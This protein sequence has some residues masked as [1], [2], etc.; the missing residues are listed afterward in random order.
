[1]SRSA[2]DHGLILWMEREGDIYSPAMRLSQSSEEAIER[3]L[4]EC[5]HAGAC[6]SIYR[7]GTH[8]NGGSYCR[9]ITEEVAARL[10]RLSLSMRRPPAGPVR[11]FLEAHGVEFF[12]SIPERLDRDL[13]ASPPFQ[14]QAPQSG[15]SAKKS[16]RRKSRSKPLTPEELRAQPQ[17]KL[18][19]AGGRDVEI[20]RTASGEAPVPSPGENDD[21]SGIERVSLRDERSLADRSAAWKRFDEKLREMG[22]KG[23]MQAQ[24]GTQPNMGAGEKTRRSASRS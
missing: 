21:A 24:S 22:V 14:M 1:M 16:A 7:Y 3:D 18:P 19:I 13:P 10:G 6:H 2:T 15:G 23:A 4:W 9:E 17:F 5:V 20:S 11:S 12:A 8:A